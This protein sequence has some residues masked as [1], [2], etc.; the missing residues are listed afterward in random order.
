MRLRIAIP[1]EHVTS[2]VLDAGLETLTRLDERLLKSGHAPP[3]TDAIK[4]RNGVRWK[5]EPPGEEH[6]DHAAMVHGRK[7]GDCDDLA[8]WKAAELRVTG[9]DPGAT[10]VVKKS[11][12]RR[13]HAIVKRSDGSFEDPSKDAGMGSGVNGHD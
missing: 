7:W 3:F 2:Q 13:W 5:P 12:P 9:E 11:G 1:E 8:P 10:A 6:F 4:G